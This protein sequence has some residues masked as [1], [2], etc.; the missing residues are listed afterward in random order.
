MI[1]LEAYHQRTKS[2]F[3]EKVKHRKFHLGNL[4]LKK[5]FHNNQESIYGKLGPNWKCP[6]KI[7][8]IRSKGAYWLSDME[9]KNSQGPGMLPVYAFTMHRTSN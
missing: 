1:R 8:G 3:N 5:I 4:V 2:V 9:G 7:V 6:Y